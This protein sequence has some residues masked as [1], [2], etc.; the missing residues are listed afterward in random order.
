VSL[1]DL[2]IGLTQTR[3]RDEVGRVD[4]WLYTD[5]VDREVE[6]LR[7]GGATVVTEPADR[8]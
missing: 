5:D 2:S 6:R 4:L 3:K 8:E 1:G 7:D